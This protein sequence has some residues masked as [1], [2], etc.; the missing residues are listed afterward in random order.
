MRL[1][2]YGELFQSLTDTHNNPNSNTPTHIPMN[3]IA[4]L[5][6]FVFTSLVLLSIPASG[7]WAEVAPYS[8]DFSVDA[9]AFTPIAQAGT[10]WSV[11]GGVYT[12]TNSQGGGTAQLQSRSVANIS[13]FG[14]GALEGFVVSADFTPTTNFNSSGATS[15]FGFAVLG[16]STL[17]NYYLVDV[18]AADYFRIY[19]IGGQNELAGASTGFTIALGVTYTITVTGTYDINDDLNLTANITSGGNS[20]TISLSSA[21]TSKTDGSYFGFR[22]RNS[23]QD[24]NMS[25]AIDN[26]S[27]SAVPEPGAFA[28][29]SGAFM[30]SLVITRRRR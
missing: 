14:S 17:S 6:K 7:V 15:T 3:D 9:G 10:S 22:N 28:L 2:F 12:M 23:S 18:S 5:S 8:N 4:C 1:V 19:E 26:F 16:N 11:G 24:P 27:I 21:D 20:K 29:F 25:I 30:M 13:N